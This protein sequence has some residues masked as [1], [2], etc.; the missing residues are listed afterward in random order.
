MTGRKTSNYQRDADDWY[1]EPRWCVDLLLDREEVGGL[2]YDPA[3]G[4]GNIVKALRARGKHAAGSDRHDRGYGY[5]HVDFLAIS[6]LI[7]QC[8]CIVTNPP[9]D[10][11]EQFVEQAIEVASH[12][13]CILA[14]LAVLESQA[15]YRRLWSTN[16]PTR[17]WVLSKRPSMPP[18]NRPDIKAA[19]GKV[20]Y[21]WLVWDLTIPR[22]TTNLGWLCPEPER[23]AA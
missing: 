13:V 22:R 4:G 6:P 3:C 19:G 11:L 18:G 17:V 15:R 2:V 8:D 20:A 1:V 10:L 5:A 12:K 16:P 23:A 7:E 21:C 14:R 9:F